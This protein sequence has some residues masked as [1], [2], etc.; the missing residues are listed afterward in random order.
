MFG[1]NGN[2]ITAWSKLFSPNQF[3]NLYDQF[4]ETFDLFKKT[5]QI[6]LRSQQLS[7]LNCRISLMS[8]RTRL[9]IH[10]ISLTNHP[11][12]VLMIKNIAPMLEPFAFYLSITFFE[13]FNM[14]STIGVNNVMK[15]IAR[16]VFKMWDIYQEIIKNL[17]WSLIFSA[18]FNIN[19]FLAFLPYCCRE[20]I[21][22]RARL[23]ETWSE[24]KPVWKL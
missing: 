7:L 10:W 6:S 17:C 19:N 24:L 21:A 20:F 2:S 4:S 8:R 18:N 12:F 22:F 13:Q 5:T 3:L 1:Q 14:A 11:V 16:L 23:H 15:A 9:L